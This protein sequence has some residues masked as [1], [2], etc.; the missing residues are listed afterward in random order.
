MLATLETC[1]L[2]WIWNEELEGGRYNYQM[3]E[4]N[5]KI[6]YQLYR[7]KAPQ[8][9]AQNKALWDICYNSV[10]HKVH[11]M[12][13]SWLSW[14][15]LSRDWA[16]FSNHWLCACISLISGLTVPSEQH[17]LTRVPKHG[18]EGDSHCHNSVSWTWMIALFHTGHAFL[19]ELQILH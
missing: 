13:T 7:H 2:N 9:H 1:E 11:F 4:Y 19:E 15:W 14:S 17:E 3:P 12:W 6:I 8:T 10:C 16:H 18:L 5:H